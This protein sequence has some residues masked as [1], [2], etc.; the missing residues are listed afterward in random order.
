MPSSQQPGWL[1]ACD[2]AGMAAGRAV[3]PG[4]LH[5]ASFSAVGGELLGSTHADE[6]SSKPFL[7]VLPSAHS[8]AGTTARPSGLVHSPRRLPAPPVDVGVQH[9]LQMTAAARTRRWGQ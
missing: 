2:A 8:A 3:V 9:G 1:T 4:G 5:V 6:S 7:R